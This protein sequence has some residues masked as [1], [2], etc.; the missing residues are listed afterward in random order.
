MLNDTV[1][2][3]N[4]KLGLIG[5]PQHIGSTTVTESDHGLSGNLDSIRRNFGT[6]FDAA[7]LG[8]VPRC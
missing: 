3:L 5:P 1:L 4:E 2:N 7:G 6:I 8:S